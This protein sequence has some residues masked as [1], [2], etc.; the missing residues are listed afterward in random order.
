MR[1]LPASVVLVLLASAC[2]SG[3]RP[4]GKRDRW[5]GPQG[6]EDVV[7]GEAR[8]A[9][10]GEAVAGPEKAPAPLRKGHPRLW[11]RRDDLPRL[12]KWAHKDNPV[13][14]RIEELTDE[15]L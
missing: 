13:W 6:P 12:R 11:I 4:F 9:G 5:E 2:E 15:F 8:D 10:W 1:L 3:C 7:F 14:Q